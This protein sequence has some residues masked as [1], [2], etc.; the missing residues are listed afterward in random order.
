M[1]GGA[2]G[3]QRGEQIRV[4]AH[5]GQRLYRLAHALGHALGGTAGGRG[6]RDA[7]RRATCVQRL[8]DQ[9][10]QQARGGGGL[11]GA[12][13]ASDQ[14][15]RMAQGERGGARLAVVV[16]R[17]REQ[18]GEQQGER[19]DACFRHRLR[20]DT[21]QAQRQ[22]ALVLAIATQI[23]QAAFQHQ[24]RMRIGDS[25]GIVRRVDPARSLEL[26]CPRGGIGPGD[27]GLD[28]CI[29][30]TETHAGMTLGHRQRRQR[31]RREHGIGRVAVQPA[32][33]LRQRMIQRAQVAALVERVEQA[34]APASVA[35]PANSA[36]SAC[37]SS[38]AKRC[39]C[40]PGDRGWVR[41]SPRQNR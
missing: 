34:H 5:C 13:A 8:R 36:S 32:Q 22:R 38:G 28:Q 17:L 31:R 19:F 29:R 37:T 35:W 6:Q 27:L 26:S 20:G 9:Q 25:G 18:A 16:S 11:A 23:E 15:Q 33:A 40:T 3:G 2:T 7:W 4:H 41:S 24:R 21:L 1:Q 39:A 14:Q 12:R 30:C 10:H